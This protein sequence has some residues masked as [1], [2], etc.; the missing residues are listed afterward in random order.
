LER[1]GD[2]LPLDAAHMA[3]RAGLAA[4]AAFA[5]PHGAGLRLSPR[6]SGTDGFY[7]AALLRS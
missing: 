4:L 7:I 5:S 2:F 1:H 3:R 6:V